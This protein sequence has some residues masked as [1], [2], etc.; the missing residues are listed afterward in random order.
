MHRFRGTTYR[1]PSIP[2]MRTTSQSWWFSKYNCIFLR[3]LSAWSVQRK[4]SSWLTAEF[5]LPNEKSRENDSASVSNDMRAD[6]EL[7]DSRLGL[8]FSLL[9][10]L[11]LAIMV[12]ELQNGRST[13]NNH[14][15]P[16][17]HGWG[18][19][20][21][22]GE[23]EYLYL[24]PLFCMNLFPLYSFVANWLINIYLM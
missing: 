16:K 23:V 19:V 5:K 3:T 24:Y 6:D 12:V 13:R 9:L 8:E 11:L 15:L 7:V 10:L 4:Y 18:T 21:G 20:S 17:S 1:L 22:E 2:A 14:W